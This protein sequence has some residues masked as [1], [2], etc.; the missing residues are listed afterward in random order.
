MNLLQ[1]LKK[2]IENLNYHDEFTIA[3][4]LYL[5][6]G[7][8]FIYNPEY[9][10]YDEKQK[11]TAY[12]EELDIENVKSNQIICS[13]WAKV[14]YNLL[15]AFNIKCELIDN[16]SHAYVI[17]FLQDYKI[18]ADLTKGYEDINRIKFGFS[19]N[20]Y[21]CLEDDQ[22]ALKLKETD[23]LLGY[24]NPLYYEE[25]LKR[26]KSHLLSA[27]NV[28]ENFAFITE[29]I[30]KKDIPIDPMGASKII[31]EIFYYLNY[32][33]YING[34]KVKKINNNGE[35]IVYYEVEEGKESRYYK[36]FANVSRVLMEE[37]NQNEYL[38]LA[39]N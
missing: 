15:K 7:Q 24:C 18:I 39:L 8:F 29:V 3:R 21:K 23:I 5:R 1:I 10:F 9:Q 31:H 33:Q 12:Q 34:V 36:L 14:F 28:K 6:S 20:H 2:E 22:F 17:I 19:T 13:S 4:Y 27:K 11:E 25:R 37:I 26:Y 30:R 35:V 16:Q 38:K 32:F